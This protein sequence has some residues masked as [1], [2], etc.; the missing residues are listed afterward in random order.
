MNDFKIEQLYRRFFGSDE[1][2]PTP[3]DWAKMESLLDAEVPPKFS[4]LKFSRSI[5]PLLI[6]VSILVTIT[7][8]KPSNFNKLTAVESE[9]PTN[10]ST[11]KFAAANGGADARNITNAKKSD[12]ITRGSVL[13]EIITTENS[14]PA[15]QVS[16]VVTEVFSSTP[17]PS[18]EIQ[19]NENK[20]F[21]IQAAPELSNISSHDKATYSPPVRSLVA[22]IPI[23]KFS[24][25]PLHES[26][27]LPINSTS[28]PPLRHKATYFVEVFATAPQV[29]G[30]SSIVK[31]D[32]KGSEIQQHFSMRKVSAGGFAFGIRWKG[33]G[34]KAGLMAEKRQVQVSTDEYRQY[35][36]EEA[37]SHSYTSVD[38]DTTIT[39]YRHEMV[40]NPTTRKYEMSLGAPVL[41]FDTITQTTVVKGTHQY[42]VRDSTRY[43]GGMQIYT[44]ELPLMFGYELQR[45]A[46]SVGLWSGMTWRRI[47]NVQM[48]DELQQ[49]FST[50]VGTSTLKKRDNFTWRSQLVVARQLGKRFSI[51]LQPGCSYVLPAKGTSASTVLSYPGLALSREQWFIEAGVRYNF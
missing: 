3:D 42:E 33:F 48:S 44:L 15:T 1:Y 36:D 31:K 14:Y 4:L 26:S 10:V 13:Q 23:R 24:S 16:P 38:V 21:I 7:L 6:P 12:R 17:A 50:E 49:G 40:Y 34:L 27:L 39:G 9:E 45:G 37:Y 30:N 32:G 29:R 25:F 43:A 22:L 47:V 35:T 11:Y 2:M 41:E 51:T 46:W 28:L 18:S 20:S 5:L 19:P 8:Q